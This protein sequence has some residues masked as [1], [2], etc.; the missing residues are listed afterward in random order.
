M[1]NSSKPGY[2]AK[3]FLW[4]P[5]RQVAR[6]WG[7]TKWR[8][9]A[10]FQ[11]NTSLQEDG[12]TSTSLDGPFCHL[13]RKA[14]FLALPGMATQSTR[15]LFIFSEENFIRKYAKIIIEWGYPFSGLFAC[16]S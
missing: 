10:N 7:V 6:R 4:S 3:R 2:V 14:A 15:S 16:L 8:G 11:A 1:T 13:T 5:V 9:V 12:D